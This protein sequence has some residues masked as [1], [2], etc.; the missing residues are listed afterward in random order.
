MSACQGAGNDGKCAE[1]KRRGGCSSPY[2]VLVK[3]RKMPGRRMECLRICGQYRPNCAPNT[4]RA[5]GSC[6]R[7][8]RQSQDCLRGR[9]L[10]APALSVMVRSAL[11]P[12]LPTVARGALSLQLKR[13]ADLAVRLC[14]KMR[15][16]LAHAH[17]L[18]RGGIPLPSPIG[19]PSRASAHPA[20]SESLNLL[21]LFVSLCRA[22]SR[23][24]SDLLLRRILRL[25]AAHSAA[26]CAKQ[27]LKVNY[28]TQSVQA[29]IA[30]ADS[31]KESARLLARAKRGASAVG[32]ETLS[33]AGLCRRRRCAW[34][35]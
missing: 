11:G 16:D 8:S 29:P 14:R 30:C 32:P 4:E 24:V 15:P 2:A 6:V 9:P 19:T 3:S 1:V 5:V 7:P 20:K 27:G 26:S 31:Q 10:R 23:D 25:I 18:A 12:V 21:S 35:W 33:E 17:R 34:I 13:S 22:I 28:C